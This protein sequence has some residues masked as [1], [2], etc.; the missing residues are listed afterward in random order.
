M[1]DASH[2][3]DRLINNRS[4]AG[5]IICLNGVPVM[6]RSN[7]QPITSLSLTESE[8]CGH[9]HV[10][11]LSVGVK[12]VRLMCWVL[13]ELGVA[14]RWPMKIWCDSTG[15]ISFKDD[16]CP[17]P[18]IRGC[19]HY[20]EDWVEELEAEGKIQVCKV[21]EMNNLADMP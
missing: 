19:F 6:W 8:I 4:Q 11:A 15:A 7:R 18:K 16:T 13:E 21:K 20:R 9:I 10:Y 5:V 2:R 17:V 12:D 1:C 14:V 3:G